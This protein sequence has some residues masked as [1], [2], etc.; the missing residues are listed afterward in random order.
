M[1]GR[2]SLPLL[3]WIGNPMRLIP[4]IL[5]L[6]AASLHAGDKPVIITWDAANLTL[7]WKCL[8]DGKQKCSID[9]LKQRM[10]RGKESFPL[11]EAEVRQMAPTL[12]RFITEYAIASEDW[13][14]GGGKYDEPQQR[15]QRLNKEREIA[16]R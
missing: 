5:L 6:L 4:A 15:Q 16:R 10:Y 12:I 14:A 8:K 7:S 3:L 9:M 13:F 1:G 11:S 2:F